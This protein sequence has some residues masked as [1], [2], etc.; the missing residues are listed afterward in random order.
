MTGGAVL[1]V[2]LRLPMLHGPLS[3][4]EGGYLAIARG[5]SHGEVLYRQVWVDR[6]QGLL[7]LF[8]FWNW[9]FRGDI[10]SVRAMGIVFGIVL[11]IATTVTVRSIAGNRAAGFAGFICGVVTATPVLEGYAANGELL[12]GTVAA[13]SIA[14]AALTIRAS[15]QPL[16]R[17]ALIGT[18]A[19]VALTL[20]QSGFDGLLVIEGWL[21]ID[22]LVARD[23]RFTM[24]HVMV[25]A[26]G[27]LVPIGACAIDG[28]ITGWGRWWWAVVEYRFHTQSALAADWGN[29]GHT[30][31]I[32]M[33]VLG[34][35]VIAAL[36]A[37]PRLVRQARQRLHTG[38]CE[39]TIML[40]IWPAVAIVAFLL[41][42]GFW[43]HYWV[44]LGAPLSA[45]AAITLSR[46]RRGSATIATVLVVPALLLASWVYT[47]PRAVWTNKAA[48][49]WRASV[50]TE[51]AAWFRNQHHA[52][53]N[54]YVL[55][56][57]A[58]LYAQTG[59]DPHYPYLWFT[60]VQHGPNAQHLLTTYIADPTRGPTFVVG[61]QRPD[62]CDHTHQVARTLAHDFTIVAH[63]DVATIYQ[64]NPTPTPRNS[65]PPQPFHHHR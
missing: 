33:G 7:L 37:T 43:R 45:L 60:E 46:V 58:A 15:R 48:G 62:A 56:A 14:L 8:R 47:A 57:S 30:M 42:G 13:C 50:N 18:C 53:P 35:V 51:V 32:A 65:S 24:R 40:L 10:V 36:V 28:A 21:L 6:P 59:S 38:T 29:L 39:P 22:V 12:A 3:A 20:K 26:A 9:M 2:A 34:A 4:D 19:G 17:W 63:V 61:Y 55:C 27:A 11:V 64:R 5:W 54:I 1:S 44:Q 41:G 49:D 31:P 25:V 16:W 52:H 23:K